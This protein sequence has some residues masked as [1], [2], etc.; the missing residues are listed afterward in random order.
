MKSLATLLQTRLFWL[1]RFL[2]LSTDFI[3][4]VKIDLSVDDLELFEC[5]RSA[6]LKIIGDLD[7]EIN[8]YLEQVAPVSKETISF[9]MIEKDRILL[10][11][12]SADEALL[13]EMETVHS[14]MTEKMKLLSRGKSVLSQYRRSHAPS[15]R[16]DK[17]L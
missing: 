7:T 3:K 8:S 16:L 6:L 10:E 1:Q 4:R 13:N 12:Q 17:T 15:D 2:V 14:K 5:N 9:Y 11:I